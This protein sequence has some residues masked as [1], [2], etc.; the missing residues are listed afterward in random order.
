[1]SV[2]QEAN[3]TS[4]SVDVLAGLFFLCWAA[5]GWWS[6]LAHEKLRQSLFAGP[7]PGPGL[8]PL[9]T[10]WILT[11]GGSGI[12]IKGLV[13]MR[14]VPAAERNADLA[15]WR[16]HLVPLAFLATVIATVFMMQRVGFL[17][18]G[19]SFCVV[20]LCALS[21]YGRPSLRNVVIAVVLAAVMTLGVYLIFARVLLVPLAL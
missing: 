6:Y 17:I 19:F 2:E 3:R 20:W 13:R 18:S 8:L 15:D 21:A 5:V 9:I 16:D 7:D 11:L 4:P 12:A 10:L 14:S 1:M